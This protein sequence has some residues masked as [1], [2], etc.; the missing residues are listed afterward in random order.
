MQG[1]RCRRRAAH[2]EAAKHADFPSGGRYGTKKRLCKVVH[3]P[4]IE[5]GAAD[6]DPVDSNRVDGAIAAGIG[7]C[8][9][10]RGPQ[11]G[12]LG[13]KA[14]DFRSGNLQKPRTMFNGRSDVRIRDS[15]APERCVD[16]ARS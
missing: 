13:A 2:I 6:E 5:V 10:N 9:N 3:E 4:L 16:L 8:R 7:P 1:K 14:I 11:E 12:V 15:A